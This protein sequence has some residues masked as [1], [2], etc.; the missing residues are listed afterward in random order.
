MSTRSTSG[1]DGYFRNPSFGE[2]ERGANELVYTPNDD[3]CGVDTFTYTLSK[4][5]FSSTATVTVDVI[6][7]N[8]E[9]IASVGEEEVGPPIDTDV[10]VDAAGI[11]EDP[12]TAPI[13]DIEEE[14]GILELEDDFAEGNM[15]E[16]LSIPVLANDIVPGGK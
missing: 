13:S 4:E 11:P 7:D 9:E 15:N 14:I 10:T 2:I 16:E 3:F 1:V 8:I 5:G 6:C 12:T